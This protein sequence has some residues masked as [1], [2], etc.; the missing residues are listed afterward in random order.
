MI[1]FL[2][3]SFQSLSGDRGRLFGRGLGDGVD[4]GSW[5]GVVLVVLPVRDMLGRPYWEVVFKVAN[6]AGV[7]R[8]SELLRKERVADKWLLFNLWPASHRQSLK[9][10]FWMCSLGVW[11]MMLCLLWMSMITMMCC[12]MCPMM[13]PSWPISCSNSQQCCNNTEQFHNFL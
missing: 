12:M 5:L 11:G 10:M 6:W 4:V 9:R 7:V 8:K 13:M 1:V 3:L 2:E